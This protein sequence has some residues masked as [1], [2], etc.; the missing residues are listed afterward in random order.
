MFLFEF[1]TSMNLKFLNLSFLRDW[2]LQFIY[3]QLFVTLMALPIIIYWGLPLSLLTFLGNLLF[4]PLL[5]IFL[6]V[7]SLIFFTEL[8]Y[9][10]N[11]FLI[12][13]LE[14]ITW[15]W[16]Y[17][18][19]LATDN[20][21]IG[22]AQ[23]HLLFLLIIPISALALVFYYKAHITLYT[24]SM[25][26]SLC[27]LTIIY[28]SLISPR[29]L[30]ATY[31]K[32]IPCNKGELTLIYDQ[33]ETI[34]IDPGYLGQHLG[35]SSWVEYTLIPTITQSVGA[36]TIDHLILTK[37]TIILIQ[38][39]ITLCTNKSVK[40]IYL[41]A[42]QGIVP[43][44]LQKALEQLQVILQKNKIKIMYINTEPI[45]ILNNYCSQKNNPNYTLRITPDNHT[46]NYKKACYTSLRITGVFNK[47][48]IEIKTNYSGL[49]KKNN[50]QV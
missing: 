20:C 42:L 18:S 38:A 7:S 14:K 25:L 19:S 9:I 39:L 22:F 21:L 34:L 11:M 13:I 35:A 37:P 36:T 32:N 46:I 8:L 1:L 28:L 41:P 33:G 16:H 27:A 30:S 29:Y 3:I 23:P 44:N 49:S 40:N 48:T 2:L 50:V 12:Y 10:P 43:E 31:I 24:T 47:K 15:L 4:S 5:T 26:A 45:T 17:I 6:T